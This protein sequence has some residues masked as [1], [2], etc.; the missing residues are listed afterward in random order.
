MHVPKKKDGSDFK[1][2]DLS[3]EQRVIVLGAVDAIFKFL[4]NDEDYVPFR[5]TILGC[6]GTGKSFII[7]TMISIVLKMTHCNDSVR[8][9]APSGG[10]AFNVQGCTI[11]RSFS[12]DVSDTMG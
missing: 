2:E 7:N 11:H 9:A 1:L 12:V 8:V 3:E 10:A 6:G 4:N 5:A